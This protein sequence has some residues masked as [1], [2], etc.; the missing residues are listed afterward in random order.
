MI[1]TIAQWQAQTNYNNGELATADTLLAPPK[2]VKNEL[3]E[4]KALIDIIYGKNVELWNAS[5]T[6]TNGRI[7]RYNNGT[8]KLYVALN[9]ASN[10]NQ[11]PDISPTYWRNV[12][13]A[14]YPQG[15]MIKIDASMVHSSVI[16]SGMVYLSTVDSLFH[17][18]I[19]SSAQNIFGYLDIN[20][21]ELTTGG[22]VTISPT[23]NFTPGEFIF[24]STNSDGKPVNAANN[25][26][27]RKLGLA[28]DADTF[29]LSQSVGSIGG[30]LSGISS[31]D[32]LYYT[33][34]AGQTLFAIP[35]SYEIGHV[36]IYLNGLKLS[37]QDFTAN[38]GNNVTL[39]APAVLGDQVDIISYR[40]LSITDIYSKREVD[41]KISDLGIDIENTL[42]SISINSVTWVN[43]NITQISYATGNIKRFTYDVTTNN[44]L[45]MTISD[46]SDSATILL[47]EYYYD[48]NNK[49]N[50]TV[51]SV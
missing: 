26:T 27:L 8:D 36:D 15:K 4:L 49:L 46:I 45:T 19:N 47:V 37:N 34:T 16:N 33:A 41:I 43:N 23:P 18:V 3:N 22:L 25:P 24:L 11:Q 50:H 6:Y 48:I 20:K 31:V 9:I 14:D 42:N 10:I 5:D 40:N 28:F 38:N 21:L 1:T 32:R 30:S 2:L 17:L 13:T 35:S 7:V 44:I 29:F 51:R 39:T 12:T